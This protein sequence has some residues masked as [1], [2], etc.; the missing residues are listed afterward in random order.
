VLLEEMLGVE[1][2]MWITCG[3]EAREGGG[4]SGAVE[5]HQDSSYA[6]EWA[7]PVANA[8]IPT[9]NELT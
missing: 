9:V 8:P 5:E 1:N 6:V 2:G 3:S 7:Y 4:K